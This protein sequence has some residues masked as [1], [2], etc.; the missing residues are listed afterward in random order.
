MGRVEELGCPD[1]NPT[2]HFFWLIGT[3]DWSL[4]VL[5]IIIANYLERDNL[6]ARMGAM[7]RCPQTFGQILYTYKGHQ[8]RDLILQLFR[9]NDKFSALVKDLSKQNHLQLNMIRTNDLNDLSLT[10]TSS[11]NS[12]Y[13]WW[14]WWGFWVDVDAKPERWTIKMNAV[15]QNAVLV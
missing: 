15:C 13:Y 3:L 5:S 7:V 9:H 12:Y 14:K 1:L 6:K 4:S 10:P 11:P 2:D 8:L